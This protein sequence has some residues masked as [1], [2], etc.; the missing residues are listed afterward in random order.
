[1]LFVQRRYKED[2]IRVTPSVEA[3]QN[4]STVSLRIEGGDEKRSQ[5]LD[6]CLVQSVPGAYKYL[7]LALQ[8]VG[9]SNLR[10]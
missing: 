1:M 5:C 6:V 3:G 9:V 8:V 7:V 2:T 4:T 10:Q